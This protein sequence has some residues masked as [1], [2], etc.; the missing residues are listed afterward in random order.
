MEIPRHWRL[1]KERYSLQGGVCPN[2]ETKSFP[3][4]Q[5]CPTCGYGSP[6]HMLAHDQELQF[7]QPV[8]VALGESLLVK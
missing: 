5:V 6:L 3:A 2:C 1:R 8:A 4:R 7:A